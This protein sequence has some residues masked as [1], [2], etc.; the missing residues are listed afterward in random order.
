LKGGET[1]VFA[2]PPGGG[3]SP[4]RRKSAAPEPERAG[5][6]FSP[7]PVIAFSLGVGLVPLIKPCRSMPSGPLTRPRR[8]SE[9]S[10]SPS[11]HNLIQSHLTTTGLLQSTK[12]V[13]ISP[14]PHTNVPMAVATARTKFCLDCSC[15]LSLLCSPIA[16]S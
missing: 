16:V 3:R 12:V 8:G 13:I 15:P 7:I 2:L 6:G 1:P 5:T 9:P 14:N 4:A 10:G 11:F